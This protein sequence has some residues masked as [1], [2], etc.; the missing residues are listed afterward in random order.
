MIISEKKI[1]NFEPMVE[2][3][4]K[5]LR[6]TSDIYTFMLKRRII[7]CKGAININSANSVIAQLLYLSSI[8]DEDIT[9]YISSGGGDVYSGLA[10]YDTMQYIDADVVTICVGH[11]MSMGA[12]LL[13]V[14][15][16]GKRFSLQNSQVMLHQPMMNLGNTFLKESDF[17]IYAKS[18]Q[19]TRDILENILSKVTGQTIEKIKKDLV[20]DLFL[21]ANDALKY[22][23]IDKIIKKKKK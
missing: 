3:T 22:G 13:A 11:A 17:S 5:G 6:T 15:T 18:L 4:K 20:S 2:E 14:G 10:I 1:D 12:F 7:F 23:L 16:P 8:S 19:K 9:M 21:T